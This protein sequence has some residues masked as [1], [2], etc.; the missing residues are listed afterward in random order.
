VLTALKSQ[1]STDLSDLIDQLEDLNQSY[2]KVVIQ[3]VPA[4]CQIRGNEKADKLAK[5]GG[6]LQQED[7]GLTY[8]VAKSYIKCHLSSNG[9]KTTHPTLKAMLTPSCLDM[10]RLPFSGFLQDTIG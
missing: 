1:H 10:P 4:H 5:Q 3:W 6:A 7:T 9:K 8:E 2:Q